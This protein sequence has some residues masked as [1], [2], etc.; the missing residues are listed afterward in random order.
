MDTYAKRL[1]IFNIIPTGQIRHVSYHSNVKRK[2]KTML[3]VFL[4]FH[5]V[6][7]NE[8]QLK[9]TDTCWNQQE[10]LFFIRIKQEQSI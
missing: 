8:D 4:C 6:G 2:W 3:G 1:T 9:S 7:T 10:W 5:L